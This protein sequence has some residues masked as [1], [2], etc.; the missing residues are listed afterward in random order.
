MA[1]GR[2]LYRVSFGPG[3]YE[4]L[5]AVDLMD[6]STIAN[7]GAADPGGRFVFGSKHEEHTEPKA[8]AFS[9]GGGAGLRTLHAPVT[10]FNGPAFGRGGDRIYFADTLEG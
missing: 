6:P 1:A 5:V 10:I 3:E 2:S 7:D 9:F 8:A 4:K